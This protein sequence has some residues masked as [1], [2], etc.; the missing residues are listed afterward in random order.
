MLQ[1]E[2]L[3]QYNVLLQVAAES[4]I[5]RPTLYDFLAHTALEFYKTDE[6]SITK[7]AYKFDWQINEEKYVND[8]YQ[9]GEL[10]WYYNIKKSISSRLGAK[11]YAINTNK[12]PR[13]NLFLG[14]FINAN[15]G[16]AD[17]TELTLGYV[18]CLPIKKRK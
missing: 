5:Y 1:Q 15:F 11:L 10:N 16:Q 8:G 3:R 18:Y 7:P 9:L 12:A 2:D 17:F 13:H 14:A 4:K 6:N